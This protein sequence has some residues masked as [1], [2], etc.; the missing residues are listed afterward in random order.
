MVAFRHLWGEDC[1]GS[2]L[3][4]RT[5]VRIYRSGRHVT[6]DELTRLLDGHGYPFIRW[7]TKAHAPLMMFGGPYLP[8]FDV[9]YDE[10]EAYR[11]LLVVDRLRA[12]DILARVIEPGAPDHEGTQIES[13]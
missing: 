4:G 8:Y 9:A 5:R 2:S 13:V 7:D 6:W 3:Q 10:A 12:E 11:A 1:K